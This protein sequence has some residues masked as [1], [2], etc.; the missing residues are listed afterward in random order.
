MNEK[1]MSRMTLVINAI[2][3]IGVGITIIA[4]P[5]TSAEIFH[6]VVS[7]L[8]SLLGLISLIFNIIK[9]KKKINILISI[10]TLAI[11]LFFFS[12]PNTFLILFPIV[13]GFYMLING[14]IKLLTYIIYKE[15]KLKGYHPTLLASIVDFIFSFIMLSNPSQNIKGLT[16]I[17][18]IYLILFGITYFYDFIKD[19]FPNLFSPSKRRFRITLPIFVS[20]MIPYNVYTKINNLLDKYITPVH[21]NNK[22]TSGNVD[23][24]IFIHVKNS[25]VGRVGHADLCFEGTVYSYGCYDESSKKFLET[26]GNGTFFTIK[27]KEKYLKFCTSH[28]KKTIFVFGITLSDKQKESIRQELKKIEEYAYRWKCQQELD[29]EHDYNDYASILYKYT[30]AKFYK[31]SKGKWKT[32]FL[33]STNCVKL[34]DKVLGA[35]GSDLLKINGIITPGAYYNYLNK[36]FKRKNSGVITKKIYTNIKK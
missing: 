13:F 20:A 8:I 35:T 21:V 26:L 14:I 32:Y 28:S 10:S 31:F 6:F 17:L 7:F 18:G 23:L 27:G 3:F 5:T 11:G 30:K 33:F 29:S 4:I 19:L 36:E 16:I 9:T 34:V 22:N 25:A 15:E 1:Y 24:E 2:I 12:K